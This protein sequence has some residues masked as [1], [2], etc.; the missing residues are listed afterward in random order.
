MLGATHAALDYV[1]RHECL[2]LV[3]E[4]ELIDGRARYVTRA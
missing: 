4:L 2:D 3:G 1:A